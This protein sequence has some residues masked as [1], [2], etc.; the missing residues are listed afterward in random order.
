MPTDKLEAFKR[1]FEKEA[2]YINEDMGWWPEIALGAGGLLAGGM[3]ARK[4]L[5]NAGSNATAASKSVD[6]FKYGKKFDK[7]IED[8]MNRKADRAAHNITYNSNPSA[9]AMNQAD[10]IFNS[11]NNPLSYKMFGAPSEEL[12]KYKQHIINRADEVGAKGE[13]SDSVRAPILEDDLAGSVVD[14]QA[15]LKAIQKI[16][17]SINLNEI[18]ASKLD[19]IEQSIRGKYDNIEASPWF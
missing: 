1:G 10:E 6:N 18:D 16:R 8:Y 11:P 14:D 7:H 15:K 12:D 17:N 4:Y 9:Q 2:Q 5:S 19:E 3:A 13:L